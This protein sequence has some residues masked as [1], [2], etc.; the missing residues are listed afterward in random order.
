MVSK[1]TL[2]ALA[3][4]A[5]ACVVAA[6][7]QQQAAAPPP[8][9]ALTAL[10]PPASQQQPVATPP[11]PRQQ[12]VS[13]GAAQE[14]DAQARAAPQPLTESQARAR[15]ILMEMA[16]YLGAL[17]AFSV[18][19]TNT[20]DVLQ[21]SGQKIEFGERRKL[22]VQ[23]PNRLRTDTERSDGA[24]TAAT[25]N[26]TEI[27]LVDAASKIYAST[28]QPGGLDESI[29]YFVSDLKMRFP[30]ALLLMSRLPVELERRVRSVEYVETSYLSGVPAHHLAVRGDTVDF[31][32]WV[33]A[34]ATPLP[35]RVVITYKDAPAQPEF[36]A[37]FTDWN[38][39]PAITAATFRLVP[40]QGAQKVAF[41][42]QLAAMGTPGRQRK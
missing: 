34:S 28:R 11:A 5:V 26:G 35:L 4:A 2:A 29:L 6:C 24:H 25:F 31:Q 18:R 19:V 13:P 14:T 23:R 38:T 15:D 27:T 21:P 9:A 32:V 8:A 1:R 30:L 41:A 12:D 3:A 39:H 17:P 22:V 33:R 36:R 7:A 37:D 40:P 20:Y 10:P 16:H 42:A